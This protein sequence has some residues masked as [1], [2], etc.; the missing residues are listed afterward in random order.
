R[1]INWKYNAEKKT[2][3][4]F[5]KYLFKVDGFKIYSIGEERK[6]VDTL[7]SDSYQI[8]IKIEEIGTYRYVITAFKKVGEKIIESIDSPIITINIE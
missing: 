1:D 7:S 3:T 2:I 4:I 8:D 6:L 5:W